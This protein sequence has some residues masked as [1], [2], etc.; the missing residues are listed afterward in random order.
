MMEWYKMSK[1]EACLKI[2][3]YRAEVGGLW[4]KASHRQKLK[5]LS[6]NNYSKKGMA[7]VVECLLSKHEA[8]SIPGSVIIN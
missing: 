6:E 5:T 4:S 2:T 7:Q 8:L 1:M 3:N